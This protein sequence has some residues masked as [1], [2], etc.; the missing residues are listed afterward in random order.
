MLL[1]PYVITITRKE[2]A[3]SLGTSMASVIR[4]MSDWFKKSIIQASGQTIDYGT[5]AA[6][7]YVGLSGSF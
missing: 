5:A 4:V 1:L 3:D 6:S 7:A 2:I